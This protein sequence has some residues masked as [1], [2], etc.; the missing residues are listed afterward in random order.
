MRDPPRKLPHRL[1]DDTVRR[2]RLPV[3][4]LGLVLVQIAFGALMAG[5]KA[6]L[7][8]NTWPLMDG[9]FIPPF[10]ALRVVRPWYE[11]FADNPALVQLDHR[12]MAYAVVALAV[13]HAWSA[14]RRAART[15]YAR[16]AA[17]VAF[18]AASQMALGITTLLLAVPLWAG[19]AHQALAICL[20]AA[21]TIHARLTG[22]EPVLFLP[23]AREP[24]HARR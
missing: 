20:L 16:R 1:Q 14:S 18:I 4:L 22:A 13:W 8:Y 9:R 19:L 6:G 17:V 7:T 12:L 3:V 5:S 23:A 24:D 2:G 21:V 10:E 15:A 11:N